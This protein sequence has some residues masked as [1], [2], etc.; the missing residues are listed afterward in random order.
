MDSVKCY[1]VVKMV[2]DEA[3]E[4]FGSLMRESKEERTMIENYCPIIDELSEKF[5]GVSYEVEVD[6]KTL[7]ITVSLVCEEFETDAVSSRFCELSN[8]AKK[9]NFSSENGEMIKIEFVFE[10]IWQKAF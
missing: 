7:E 3:T 5:G 6:D 4:Q 8:H 9:I 1:D 2:L 10:G